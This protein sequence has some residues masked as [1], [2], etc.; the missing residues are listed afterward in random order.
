LLDE[1]TSA[2]DQ[3]SVDVLIDYLFELE[4]DKASILLSSHDPMLAE[5]L[6]DRKLHIKQ[7]VVTEV[8]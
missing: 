4:K 5:R 2:L 1:P 6:G 7:G 8:E 3:E